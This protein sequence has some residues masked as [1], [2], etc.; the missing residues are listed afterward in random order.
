M[1]KT[2]NVLWLLHVR[3]S[4]PMLTTLPNSFS[5]P[6][7]SYGQ[8]VSHIQV[9]VTIAFS[10]PPIKLKLGL[11]VRERLLI[12]THLDQSNYL[13]NQKQGAVNK[14]GFTLFI[15][16]FHCYSRALKALHV[17]QGPSDLPVGFTGLDWWT[18]SN[19]PWSE[20]MEYF[21]SPFPIGC[22]MCSD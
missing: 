11:Q 1:L 16:L 13:P 22:L 20:P 18:S 19:K 10:T 5:H 7:F 14:C 21:P 9:L 2:L 15:R 17:L 4:P 6:S 3:A 12:A 8:N